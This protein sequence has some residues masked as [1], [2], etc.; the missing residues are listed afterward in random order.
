[1]SRFTAQCTGEE[2]GEVLADQIRGSR[3]LITGVTPGSIGGE[4]A[5]QLA[6]HAP[7]LL[8]L[9]GRTLAVLQAAQQVIQTENPSTHTQLLVFDLSSQAS[10]RRAAKEAPEGIDRIVNSAGV[11]ATPYTTTADG[12]EL[13]FGTNHIGHFLFTNLILSRA[14][15]RGESVRVV[16]VSSLGHKRG[17]VRFADWGFGGGACYDK[18]QA[19]GQSKT[20]NMLF[21][22]ALAEKLGGRGI[23]SFSLYPGRMVTGIG[24]SLTPEEWVKAGWKHEDGTIVDDPRLNWRSLT[25]GAATLIVAAYDPSIS[26]LNG[27]YMV[28]NQVNNGE[29]AAYA[30]DSLNA[31][32]LWT[33]SEEIVGQ[34]FV[35]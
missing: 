22:V 34:R 18:W 4:A 24:R 9:A 1:M 35:Y 25:Q 11:M 32:R 28:N 33:M 19:Y 26:D 20:A 7:A 27:S 17:P 10:I 15:A 3:V 13:Q 6:R 21:S 8:V 23:G 31:E 29:A 5:R 16:N 2:V 14:V 30:L 12:V